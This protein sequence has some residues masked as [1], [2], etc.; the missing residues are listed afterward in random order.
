MRFL[1]LQHHQKYVL[2]KYRLGCT[3]LLFPFAIKTGTIF[4]TLILVLIKVHILDPLDPQGFPANA[5]LLNNYLPQDHSNEYTYKK[6]QDC[7]RTFPQCNSVLAYESRLHYIQAMG[8]LVCHPQMVQPCGQRITQLLSPKPLL[9]L[10]TQMTGPTPK[11]QR[12]IAIETRSQKINST[13]MQ[14]C[15]IECANFTIDHKK[16]WAVDVIEI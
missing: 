7:Q 15:T 14:Y 1:S 9:V 3:S 11:I 10:L 13:H 2:K 12:Q 6:G 16:Y 5:A 4:T 8:F